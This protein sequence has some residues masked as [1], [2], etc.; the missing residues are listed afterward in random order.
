MFRVH[1][2]GKD[3]AAKRCHLGGDYQL[4]VKD[5]SLCLCGV[6]L[7]QVIY[8]W[9]YPDIR[10]YG[11]TDKVFKFVAGRSSSSGEGMISVQ[12]K[13]G[14][15][16]NEAVHEKVRLMKKSMDLESRGENP[17]P[18][19]DSPKDDQPDYTDPYSVETHATDET[20]TYMNQ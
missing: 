15:A 13:D 9:P 18:P 6:K 2:I 7:N 1:I 20:C 17:S 16:I 4:V 8:E 3:G 14:F 5:S 12:T 10:C 19:V 11:Y